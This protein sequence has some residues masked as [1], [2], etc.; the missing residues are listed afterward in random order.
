MIT[1]WPI[2]DMPAST[3]LPRGEARRRRRN[4]LRPVAAASRCL[5]LMNAD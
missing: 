4:T 3:R 1:N 2:I 5:Y